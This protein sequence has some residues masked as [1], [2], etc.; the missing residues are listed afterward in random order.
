MNINGYI[1]VRRPDCTENNSLG[2]LMSVDGVYYCGISRDMW[3]DIQ[4]CNFNKTL[5]LLLKGFYD[6]LMRSGNDGSHIPILTNWEDVNKFLSITD[7]I[8]S[9]NEIIVVS[10]PTLDKVK[11]TIEPLQNI[12]WIGYDIMLLGS[13]SL[14]RHAIFEN[15]LFELTKCSPLNNYGLFDNLNFVDEF[16]E[17]YNEYAKSDRV[18][19]L[20]ES[21]VGIEMIRIGRPVEKEIL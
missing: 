10:S 19:P 1:L 7:E 9:K 17:K 8:R 16:L 21:G 2:R 14:I 13:W 3:C 5:P 11:G 15:R 4:N 6:K 20:I 18:D 12:Q